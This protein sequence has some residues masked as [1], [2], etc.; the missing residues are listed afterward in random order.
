M[1]G[2]TL[3]KNSSFNRCFK[4][5]ALVSGR[6]CINRRIERSVKF[7]G[8]TTDVCVGV[9]MYYV[10][11]SSEYGI[12]ITHSFEFLIPEDLPKDVKNSLC[13]YLKTEALN[14]EDE[15]NDLYE[16]RQELRYSLSKVENKFDAVMQ[17]YHY[18]RGF[19]DARNPDDEGTDSF[20]DSL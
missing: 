13:R 6:F 14:E 15:L 19:D 4:D 18:K 8:K 3:N 5:I 20:L 10:D 7:E 16:I 17:R 9:R 1:I 12:G 2:F 11:D